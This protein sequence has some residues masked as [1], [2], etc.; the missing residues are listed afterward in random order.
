MD[1][2]DGKFGAQFRRADLRHDHA[3]VAR[4]MIQADLVE[5]VWL[6]HG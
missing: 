1:R 3:Q 6:E 5:V 4:Q 2:L